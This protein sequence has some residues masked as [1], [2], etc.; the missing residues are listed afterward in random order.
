M[1]PDEKESTWWIL[2]AAVLL[3]L[4][5]SLLTPIV[6]VPVPAT[7]SRHRD[8]FVDLDALPPPPVLAAEPAP[9]MPRPE[10][11]QLQAPAPRM[12]PV[13]RLPLNTSGLHADLTLAPFGRPG[14][15][16]FPIA[17]AGAPSPLAAIGTA[18]MVFDVSQADAMPRPLARLTP[19][20]PPRARLRRIEGDVVVEFVVTPQGSVSAAEVVYAQPPDMFDQTALQAVKHWRFEPGVKDG[21]PVAVRVRQKLTF[22]LEE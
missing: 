16:S 10:A 15:L 22:R 17:S 18:D 21:Q 20:Y 13:A 2:P 12:A 4:G 1:E 8:V 6:S 11:P 5:I 9:N 19:M 3:A 14:A 7:A